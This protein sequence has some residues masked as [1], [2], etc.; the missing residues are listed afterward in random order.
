MTASRF[1]RHK[2]TTLF[3]AL[4]AAASLAQA[5]DYTEPT[6]GMRFVQ[7]PAGSYIMGDIY[8]N[9]PFAKPPHKVTLEAF[10]MGVH[11]VTFAQYDRFCKDTGRELPED[12]GWGRETRP[13]V[14]VSRADAMAFAA[15]LSE[16]TG[17]KLRL[18]SESEWEYAARGG[19]STP[20]WWGSTLGRANANCRSCGSVWDGLS[21]APV[22]SF[23]A[24]P[25]GL[26]DVH[27]NVYEW[28][29]DSWHANYEGAPT[30]GAARIAVQATEFVSRGGSF[31]EV[32]SSLTVFA[33]NWTHPT[34]QS[35]IGF[36]L[37]MED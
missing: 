23:S 8:G 32:P 21:T 25:F 7:I 27:G 24:N 35:D 29:L 10:A 19:K 14:N 18:P 3:I 5:A 22:G 37:V 20:Y 13:V 4:L 9:D 28:V 17:K 6:T 1:T 15:W 33:R 11:E 2:I 30:N 26:Y 16:K 31:Q 34:P 36:R 12:N